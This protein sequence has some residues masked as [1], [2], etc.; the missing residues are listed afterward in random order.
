MAQE[1]PTND[2]WVTVSEPEVD[3]TKI[4]FDTIGDEFI[5]TYL[6]M[7]SIVNEDGKFTQLRFKGIGE[8]E[9]EIFFTNANYSLN[10]SFTKVRPGRVVRV[11]FVEEKDTGQDSPMRIFQVDVKK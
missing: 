2:G 5:G 7:R 8:A 4:V 6:G 11:T 10:K 9:G 1:K 3:E